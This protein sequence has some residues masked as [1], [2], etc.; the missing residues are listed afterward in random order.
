MLTIHA[1]I[2]KS[3]MRVILQS[4]LEEIFPS[5]LQKLSEVGRPWIFTCQSGLLSKVSRATVLEVRSHTV[6]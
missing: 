1:L 6:C 2:T 3:K 5:T 4:R